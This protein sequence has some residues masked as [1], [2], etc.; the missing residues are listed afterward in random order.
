MLPIVQLVHRIVENLL[1]VESAKSP[2][3]RAAVD[4]QAACGGRAVPAMLLQRRQRSLI[5]QRESRT[6]RHPLSVRRLGRGRHL[7]QGRSHVRRRQHRTRRR[8]R[9]A[10]EHVAKF[11]DV[12][13]PR[14]AS[15][16]GQGRC[17][18]SGDMRTGQRRCLGQPVADEHL[19]VFEPFPERRQMKARNAQAEVEIAAESAVRRFLLKI[20]VRRR[21]DANVDTPRERLAQT[22]DFAV[23]ETP[24]EAR[25]NR[26]GISRG[27]GNSRVERMAAFESPVVALL[28]RRG[29][30]CAITSAAMGM[31]RSTRSIRRSALCR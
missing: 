20:T 27:T 10:F 23:V 9:R 19:D 30:S 25:L 14:M 26:K 21:D 3:Q 7:P 29:S 6:G 16:A 12:P 17:G 15:Q 8:E 18:D 4:T 13:R 31:P 22:P 2:P 24:Q 28:N 1:D 11:T 5:V